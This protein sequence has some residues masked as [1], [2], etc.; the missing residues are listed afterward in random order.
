MFILPVYVFGV[1]NLKYSNLHVK[2]HDEKDCGAAAL[3]MILRYFGAF[4]PL[5]KLRENVRVDAEGASIYGVVQAAKMYGIEGDALEGGIE[6]LADSVQ[7]E[8]VVAP[9]IARIITPEGYEHFVTIFEVTHQRLIMGDPGRDVHKITWEEFGYLYAGQI[10]TF[11]VGDHFQK[12]PRSYHIPPRYRALIK[13]YQDYLGRI[14]ALS[15]FLAL[16]SLATSL[17]FGYVVGDIIALNMEP[18]IEAVEQVEEHEPPHEHEHEHEENKLENIVG[19]LVSPI[20]PIFSNLWVAVPMIIAFYLVQCL[21]SLFRNWMLLHMAKGI[22]QDILEDYYR[23]LVRLPKSFTDSFKAGEILQRME[24]TDNIRDA[25]SGAILTV[26]LNSLYLILGGGILYCISAPLFGVAILISL[27]YIFTILYFRRPLRNANYEIMEADSNVMNHIKQTVDGAGTI[28]SFRLESR[29]TKKA[30]RLFDKYTSKAFKA[31]FLGN[32]QE[33]IITTLDSGG[34][35]LLLTIGAWLM[36]RGQ[37]SIGDIMSFYF[38]YGHFSAPVK[39]LTNLQPVLQSATIAAERLDDVFETTKESHGGDKAVITS[40]ALEVENLSFRYA[41]REKTL[42]DIS[43]SISEKQHIAIIGESGSGKSTLG[44]LLIRLYDIEEGT[45]KIDGKP[46]EAYDLTEL[47]RQVVYVSQ[48]SYVFRDSL[49]NNLILGMEGI[50][51]EEILTVCHMCCLE[52]TISRLPGGL[53]TMM[54]ENGANLSTGERERVN[55]ARALL[56]KPKILLVDEVTSNLDYNIERNI[57]KLLESLED[58]TC[59]QITH[60]LST[61]KKCDKI[62]VLKDGKIVESGSFDD[63]YQK[64][65]EMYSFF[66]SES[67]D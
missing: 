56:V 57:I 1:K 49:R 47:R 44:K 8:E 53:D 63:L 51:D 67:L 21:L 34:M 48:D 37:V 17:L 18:G 43:F 45:I 19:E 61:I 64:K 23:A 32:A 50:S 29:W 41:H 5:Y 28:K 25:L 58:T 14:F 36:T 60:R 66:A 20:E 62:I 4:I 9:F 38:I 42:D 16:I 15:V 30:D 13:H 55:I 10:I 46:I 11:Q 40:P 7:K 59:V 22:N 31:G 35:I 33:V 39:S 52:K 3:S 24:D 26:F 65:G 54:D 6:E 2:Q 12:I 27:C